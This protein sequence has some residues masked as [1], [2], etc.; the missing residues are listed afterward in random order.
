M[1]IKFPENES[2]EDC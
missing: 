1:G 2:S